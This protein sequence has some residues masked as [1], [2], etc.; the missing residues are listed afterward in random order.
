VKSGGYL[1]FVIGNRRVNG[2]EIPTSNAIAEYGNKLGLELVEIR[3]RNI[4]YKRMPSENSP[5][6]IKG[7]KGKT[8]SK[9]YIVIL[10]KP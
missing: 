10:K 4:L 7:N 9:E 3:N 6:N 2:V 8:M 5:S 1:I